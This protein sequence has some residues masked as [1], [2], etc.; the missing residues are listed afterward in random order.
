ME[1]CDVCG[2][3]TLLP[4]KFE[5]INICK[6]CFVKM[7]GPFWKHS[8]DKKESAE[9][10]RCQA[11]EAA[12]KM[13]C[14]AD[15]VSAVNSYFT[16]QLHNMKLCDCC[17]QEVQTLHLIGKSAICGHCFKKIEC[18]AWKQTQYESNEEVQINREKILKVATRNRF[19]ELII[20]DI[21]AHFDAKINKELLCVV[22]GDVGQRL[23]VYK[24]HAVLVT[25]GDFNVDEI[26]EHY[27]RATTS[28]QP[29]E[30]LIDSKMAA[31][32]ARNIIKGNIV[33][34]GISV[35][36][37]VAVDVASKSF[38]NNKGV[39]RVVKGG[40]SIDYSIFDYA[41]YRRCEDNEIGFIRFAN[42][43]ASDKAFEDIVFFFDED[44]PKIDKA[45]QCVR[46]GMN[47]VKNEKNI[48]KTEKVVQQTAQPQYMVQSSV[49]DE[50]LKFK[51]LLDMG[52]ITAE[53]FEAKKK[54]LLEM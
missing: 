44:S 22:D 51:N 29:K 23:K 19:P 11:L 1:K 28:L 37:S 7:N 54:Q 45:Y 50:L 2:K 4:E 38:S 13:N 47:N 34:A 35:A 26:A 40:F 16:K 48:S 6:I 24:D 39:F 53:E 33:K 14:S 15:V 10:H 20:Q 46:D 18:E 36:T 49:A 21:N 25:T 5:K 27:G 43:K 12:H 52:V 42:N 32:L 41:E 31:S 17:G 3:T 30:K 8:F 9:K